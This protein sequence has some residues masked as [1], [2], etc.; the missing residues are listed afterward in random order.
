[1][2]AHIMADVAGETPE[3]KGLVSK[4]SHLKTKTKLELQFDEYSREQIDIF[5]GIRS[6]IQLLGIQ[7]IPVTSVMLTIEGAPAIGRLINRSVN[8]FSRI[9]FE[10]SSLDWE[11]RSGVVE[12]KGTLPLVGV[13]LAPLMDVIARMV[14]RSIA[15]ISKTHHPLT[16]YD[17]KQITGLIYDA[18]QG[19]NTTAIIIDWL[20][21]RELVILEEEK[22]ARAIAIAERRQKAATKRAK[23]RILRREKA[24]VA[25]AQSVM[26]GPEKNW[27]GILTDK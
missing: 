4:A 26:V 20:T 25:R 16:L 21:V 23:D 22:A 1:M 8:A 10:I 15:P 11:D 24:K 9:G 13:D 27:P 14:M 12:I 17:F 18:D 7:A 2:Y 6:D 3:M 5:N 19:D